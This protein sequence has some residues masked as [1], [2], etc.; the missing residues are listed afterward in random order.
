MELPEVLVRDAAAWEQWLDGH[1]EGSPGAW[2]VLAKKGVTR[3]TSL[4]YDQALAEAACYGWI[5]G[6][7]SRRDETTYRQRF[8]PRRPRSAWSANNVALAERLISEGRMRPAG[9]AAVDR[10]KADGRWEAAYAG[11]AA[12]EVPP[13]LAEALAADPAALAAFERLNRLNRYAVLYRVSTA[14]SPSAGPAWSNASCPCS[15]G[16]RP[17]TRKRVS[18][19][20]AKWSLPRRREQPL[21][22][23]TNGPG[24]QESA[25][26]PEAGPNYSG[27]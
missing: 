22:K 25:P 13:D 3:P 10:A 4:T 24:R 15:R 23:D 27:S 11:S 26:F 12:M 9:L 2:L 18:S 1:H 17:S 6:Q 5:D 14:T 21:T 7:L 20:V 8:T 16:V 19:R